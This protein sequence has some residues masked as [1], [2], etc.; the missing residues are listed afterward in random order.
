[1]VSYRFVTAPGLGHRAR[2]SGRG[3]PWRADIRHSAS[4]V[5]RVLTEEVARTAGSTRIAAGAQASTR[6]GGRS[7]RM[8]GTEQPPSKG[9]VCRWPRIFLAFQ[10]ARV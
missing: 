4:D 2:R 9:I 5:L 8:W 1:M 6:R 10:V 7:H 3:S